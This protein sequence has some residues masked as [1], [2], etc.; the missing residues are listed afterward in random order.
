LNEDKIKRLVNKNKFNEKDM[1]DAELYIL[2]IFK[3]NKDKNRII[4]EQD[5]VTQEEKDK[6]KEKLKNN[7]IEEKNKIKN[8][9]SENDNNINEYNYNAKDYLDD[10]NNGSCNY[11]NNTEG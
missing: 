6:E 7:E 11:N 10:N 3:G 4:E 8:D 1:D 9:V 5:E 2:S